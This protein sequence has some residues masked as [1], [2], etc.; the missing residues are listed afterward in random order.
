MRSATI[1]LRFVAACAAAVFVAGC[2][3]PANEV[4][5]SG[6]PTGSTTATTSTTTTTPITTTTSASPEA[7]GSPTRQATPTTAAPFPVSAKLAR[8]AVA[9][10]DSLNTPGRLYAVAVYDRANNKLS[11]G[12]YATK[13][14][15][16]ASVIKLFVIVELLHEQE[17]GDIELTDQDRA[18]IRRALSGSDDSAM[19]A[20]WGK[21][22]GMRALVAIKDLAGLHQTE[23]PQD[24]AQWGEATIS[25][26]DTVAV[27]RYLLTKLAPDDRDLVLDALAEPTHYGLADDFDQY[28]GF[29]G[30]G[31]RPKNVAA[32]QGWIGYRPY[33]LLHS[34]A[35]LGSRHQFI[36][37]VLT[38]QNNGYSYPDVAQHVTEV[39]GTLLKT[40]GT[41]ATK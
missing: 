19:N 29:L 24:P 41:A 30:P 3:G 39:A 8:T 12:Q 38:Q 14:I 13:P 21:Y 4:A 23:P 9:R 26:A 7:K 35:L 11:S 17:N 37:V 32:K 33:R 28:F 6:V 18:W 15:M 22:N 40:L 27:Y 2:A 1:G 34:S 31:V 5:A 10:A 25:A 20:L 16:S 36:A